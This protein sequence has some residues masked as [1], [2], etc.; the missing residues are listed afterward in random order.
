MIAIIVYP[1]NQ[2]LH[3]LTHTHNRYGEHSYMYKEARVMSL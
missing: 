1:T 2:P 3:I